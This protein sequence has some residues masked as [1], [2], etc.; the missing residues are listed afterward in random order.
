MSLRRIR[1]GCKNGL[2][3]GQRL[4]GVA[5]LELHPTHHV[6]GERMLPRLGVDALRATASL[7]QLAGGQEGLDLA[8]AVEE[9]PR[10]PGIHYRG[11]R[12]DERLSRARV[13]ADL[14]GGHRE[15]LP[16]L[17]AALRLASNLFEHLQGRLRPL[18]RDRCLGE[19]YRRTHPHVRLLADALE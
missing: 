10:A 19:P 6:V 2:A 12:L 4:L 8:D 14:S 3:V 18:P 17:A 11:G 13:L 7:G 1:L 5:G 9:F 15:R 16:V